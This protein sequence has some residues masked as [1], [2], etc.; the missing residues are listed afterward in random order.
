MV[1]NTETVYEFIPQDS[2]LK[3]FPMTFPD[4]P[5]KANRILMDFPWGFHLCYPVKTTC[6]RWYFGTDEWISMPDMLFP[7]AMVQDMIRIN[8]TWWILGGFW[9]WQGP[10]SNISM[11]KAS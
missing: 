10:K 9:K 7:H 2:P 3:G 8:K 6:Y 5:I 11:Y 4:P 1:Y